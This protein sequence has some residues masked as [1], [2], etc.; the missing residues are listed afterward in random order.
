MRT[1]IFLCDIKEKVKC[2]NCN[3]I[4]K[5]HIFGSGTRLYSIIHKTLCGDCYSEE[6]Q[7]ELNSGKYFTIK[8]RG[9]D[10]E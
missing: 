3:K 6:F 8:L 4:I 5:G 2:D 10:N 7:K 1:R 9:K